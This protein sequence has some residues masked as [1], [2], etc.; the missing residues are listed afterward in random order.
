[1]RAEIALAVVALT[2]GCTTRPAPRETTPSAPVEDAASPSIVVAAPVR[3]A[4]MEASTAT[5]PAEDISGALFVDAASVSG[6]KTR[7]SAEPRCL[8][9]Q[10]YQGDAEAARIAQDLFARFHVVAGVEVAHTMNG[11]YRGM[12]RIEPAVPTGA[13]RRHLEWIA[14]AMDDFD[15][16][17]TELGRRGAAAQYRFRPITLK[18]M[19]SIAARTPSAYASEWTVAWNLAGSLHTSADA[20]RETL[21]HEIFHLNDEEKGAWSV[22]ALG[23]TYDAIVKRCGARTACLAPY[24]PNDTMVRGGTYYSFQPGNDV[25]EYAAE[26]ALRYYREQRAV[27][28]GQ[29]SGRRFRCGPPEN[30]LAWGLVR[31]TF[32]GGVDLVPACVTR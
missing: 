17:F 26:L 24:S 7:C 25:R 14:L 18:F 13:E 11:G 5:A 19:R 32:F 4:G 16:F 9:D 1:M 29:P 2:A 20:A 23:A 8:I 3:D 30:V 27:L 15:R 31:D 6:A 22:G 12:I 21:F 10:R 28:R